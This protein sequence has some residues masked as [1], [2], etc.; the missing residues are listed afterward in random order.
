MAQEMEHL[1]EESSGN[2]TET[3]VTLNALQIRF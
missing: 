1:I 3:V 2:F